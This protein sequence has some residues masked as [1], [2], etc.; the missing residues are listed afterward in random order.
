MALEQ[1]FVWDGKAYRSLSKVAGAITVAHR[2]GPRFFG[3]NGAREMARST[4]TIAP[5]EQA[6]MSG[7]GKDRE[8]V[9]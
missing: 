2:N 7:V 5:T 3:L 9:P 8:V 6:G 1:G 4:A